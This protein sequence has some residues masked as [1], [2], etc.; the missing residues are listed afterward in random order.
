MIFNSFYHFS[1]EYGIV[2][3]DDFNQNIGQSKKLK[4]PN[5]D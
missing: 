2:S 3:E 4:V 5:I 1:I